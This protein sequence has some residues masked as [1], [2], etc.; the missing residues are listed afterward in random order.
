[1][2]SKSAKYY[3]EIYASMDKDYPAEANRVNKFIQKHKRSKGKTLL[4]VACGTGAHAGPLSKYYKVEGLDLDSKML[5]VA[6]KKHPNIRFHQGDMISFDLN[7]QFD[8]IVCL[9]SSIGYVKTKS[10]LQKAIKAMN[11][12]LLPGGALLVEP[13]FA[14]EQWA[15]GHVHMV[16]IN[17]PDIKITR[18]SR[19]SR[20]G[21][22]SILD[23]HYLIGTSKGVEH[24]LE[25]HELGLFSHKEYLDAFRA[26]GLSVTHDRKGLSGRGLYIGRK[27]A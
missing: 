27:P 19:S 21:N 9:F 18:M 24:S 4:D 14:P 26:A 15:V 10:K 25:K 1:M 6:R 13:W 11:R 16:V 7:R 20:K 23:F 17:H 8:V 12:H 3:D 2:F 22:I 5:S